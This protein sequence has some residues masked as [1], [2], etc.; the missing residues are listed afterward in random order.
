[1]PYIWRA[2]EFSYSLLTMLHSPEGEYLE[3]VRFRR[4]L[5]ES[6]LSQLTTSLTFAKNVARNYVGI[7]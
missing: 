7:V 1:M 3:D 4:K 6:K 2:Q 5:S